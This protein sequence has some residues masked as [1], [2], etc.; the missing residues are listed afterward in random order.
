MRL[1]WSGQAVLPASVCSSSLTCVC[2]GHGLHG[3][4]TLYSS[5]VRCTA[6]QALRPLPR[7][8]VGRKELTRSPGA[9]SLSLVSSAPSSTS[10]HQRAAQACRGAP[11]PGG[12]SLP[13]CSL[14][15]GLLRAG[16]NRGSPKESES[17][18][19]ARGGRCRRAIRGRPR[20]GRGHGCT[21]ASSSQPPCLLLPAHPPVRR[22]Q[23]G[24]TRPG[25]GPRRHCRPRRLHSTRC[26]PACVR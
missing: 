12:C 1:V 3:R 24:T 14:P 10:H 7:A 5:S 8:T 13:G 25:H 16:R 2:F 6:Q 21:P 19:S 15:R 11:G 23:A 22:P 20:G 17:R 18:G 26:G 9:P 4:I